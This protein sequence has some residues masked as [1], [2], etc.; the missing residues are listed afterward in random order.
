LVPELL[1]E[2]AENFPYAYAY[3]RMVQE[4]DAK[5][6]DF[7]FVDLNSAFEKLMGLTREQLLNRTVSGFFVRDWASGFSWPELLAGPAMSGT[8]KTV[9]RFIK[10]LNTDLKI[11]AYSA[12]PGTVIL[13]LQPIT[14]HRFAVRLIEQQES[15]LSL[16]AKNFEVVFNT[17]H[18]AMFLVEYRDGEYRYLRNNTAHQRISGF[19][20][21]AF[22]GKTPFELLGKEHGAVVFSNYQRCVDRGESISY[23]Q[24]L[25]F[26]QG[27]TWLTTLTPLFEDGAV[28]YIMGSSKDI[29]AQIALKRQKE[30]L[31]ERLE[32]MFNEHTACMLLIDP[33]SGK[34][35]DA[36]PAACSY[37]G[38]SK[39]ELCRMF[40][41]EIN[42]L[43]WQETERRRRLAW[44]R[45]QSHFL[46]N[47]RLR[48]GE[49]RLVD[50]YSCPITNGSKKQL[51]SI[52]VDA[53]DREKYRESLFREKELLRTTLLSIGDAVLTTDTEGRITQ[54]NQAAQ[55]ISGWTSEE[56]QNRFF[57]EM[58]R[59]R[60]EKTGEEV[61]NPIQKV[62]KT[63]TIIG[64]ANHTYLINKYGKSVPI[65]D[66]AAPIRDN[67]GIIFGVVMVFRDVTLEKTQEN[68][69]LFLS[70]H[71]ALTSLY[72]RRYL[73]SEMSRIVSVEEL[74]IAVVMGDVNGLKI[75]NDVFGHK[76]GDTLLQS[77]A[78]VL[79]RNCRSSDIIV[80]WGGDEFVMILPH[81]TESQVEHL[82]EKIRLDCEAHS[83]GGRILS[84]STGYAVMH[85]RS[86]SLEHKLQEA[87]EAMYHQ[88]LLEGKSYRNTIITALLAT[89]SAKSMETEEHAQRLQMI[90]QGIGKELHLPENDMND[91]SLL[92]ILHDIGKVGVPKHILEKEGP[93]TAEE[94][95]EMRKHSEIGYRI[96]QTTPEL[97]KVAEYILAHHERWDGAGYPSGLT[98][99]QIPLVCR[100]LAVADAYDA[101]TNDRVYRKALPPETAI[102][103]LVTNAGS[104]FDPRIV[105]LFLRI[106]AKGFFPV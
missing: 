100:I 62:L 103:E 106:S 74:P 84:V 32:S 85:S 72:N 17:T 48:S 70:Y 99:E 28:R 56:V 26:G 34:I 44:D 76:T 8:T 42:T 2:V 68:R 79:R 9:T 22:F 63:G 1:K 90:C 18:D 104:Q 39:E 6:P 33:E 59:L 95:K 16:L 31:L 5:Y 61:E 55:N 10:T 51:F 30:A 89:L 67:S 29:T 77:V 58:F 81:T 96:A 7:V 12:R 94:W 24:A 53:T 20:Q 4:K 21:Q 13:L 98:E 11:T 57:S 65:A 105:D 80:R 49:I 45:K 3:L 50:V 64:L 83:Q 27:V 46:M 75:T 38:Y 25:P 15:E 37:Y 93:L 86:E 92:A 69:I 35:L 43:S 40:I 73:E 82:L 87:E 14:P 41:S 23:L 88:K 66:S 97:S 36:N 91:L 52:I 54:I 101:M 47:H 78:K 19:S 71:D 102:Q 60:N